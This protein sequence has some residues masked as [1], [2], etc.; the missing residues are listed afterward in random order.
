MSKIRI[1][2]QKQELQ[3]LRVSFREFVIRRRRRK[4]LKG[5]VREIV[6]G[7]EA[8][9]NTWERVH[10][11]LAAPLT[12]TKNLSSGKREKERKERG[13]KQSRTPLTG[14]FAMIVANSVTFKLPRYR[15]AVDHASLHCLLIQINLEHVFRIISYRFTFI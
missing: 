10:N 9:E 13:K 5:S 6:K 11:E 1:L 15:Y 14:I 8:G 12:V 3:S 4:E 2:E 7:N